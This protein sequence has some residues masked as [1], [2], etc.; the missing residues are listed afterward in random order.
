MYYNYKYFSVYI[1]VYLCVC[2]LIWRNLGKLISKFRPLSGGTIHMSYT[3][4]LTILQ[5]VIMLIQ[6]I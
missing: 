2:H 1:I 3:Q 4:R 5:F 6:Y